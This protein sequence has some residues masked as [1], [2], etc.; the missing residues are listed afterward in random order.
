MRRELG[1]GLRDAAASGRGRDRHLPGRRPPGGTSAA[2]SATRS[3]D[4]GA[5]AELAGARR[6]DLV[7]IL[8]AGAVLPAGGRRRGAARPQPVDR[9]GRAAATRSTSPASTSAEPPVARPG[10]HRAR[11]AQRR[12]SRCRRSTRPPTGRWRCRSRTPTS[13]RALS[14]L[15]AS[16]RPDVVH[17]HNWIINSYLPLSAARRLPLVYS[18]HDYSHVCPTKR[19]MFEDEPCSGPGLR[20]CFTCTTDWYGAGRGPVIQSMVRTGRPIRNRV[21]DVFT[22][23]VDVRRRGQPARR[24]GRPLAGGAQLRAR[25]AAL[26][27]GACRATRRCP[28]GDYLFFAGDLSTRRASATLL[29]AY[30]PARPG[31]P[32]GAA[33][34]RAARRWTC[35]SLPAG[36]PGRGEV[37]PRPGRLRASRTP[38]PRC[39]P[40]SGRTRARPRCSRR[41]RSA[42]RW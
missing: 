19:L 29:A 27:V 20:K 21:V 37:G 24:A 30:A 33:H 23:V 3:R 25:R 9:A 4:G 41:W 8:H 28:T 39:C 40:R 42:R 10:R 18:L 1:R 26:A 14:R 11:A 17:A 32:A 7:R 6:R 22:P 2:G 16:V 15:V 5:G 31:H 38:A 35:P 13:S 36:R 34:G 12:A